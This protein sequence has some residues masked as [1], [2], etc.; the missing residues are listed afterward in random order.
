LGGNSFMQGELQQI[1]NQ[2][3]AMASKGKANFGI[4]NHNPHS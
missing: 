2:L 1:I 4:F 3:K